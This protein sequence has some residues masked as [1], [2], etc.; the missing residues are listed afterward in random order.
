[1]QIKIMELPNKTLVC[2]LVPDAKLGMVMCIQLFQVSITPP[3][4][5][6]SPC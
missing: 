5:S 2:T 4:P 1:M 6:C 3:A